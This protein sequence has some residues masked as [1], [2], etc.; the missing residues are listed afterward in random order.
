[1]RH[2]IKMLRVSGLKFHWLIVTMTTMITT[3]S[4]CLPAIAPPPGKA[5]NMPGHLMVL[6]VC[7]IIVKFGIDDARRLLM[8]NCEGIFD[9]CY[10]G[11][12]VN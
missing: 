10:F 11:E 1:M 9:T 6:Q 2:K 3:H 12:M 7:Q 4:M 5:G 8:L